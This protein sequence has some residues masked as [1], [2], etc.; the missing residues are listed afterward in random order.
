M[1]TL[2]KI[3]IKGNWATLVLP[4][5]KDNSIDFTLL[6]EQID[7]LISA[8]VD[9]IYS[10][11]STGEFYNISETEFDKCSELLAEKCHSATIDFQVGVS[12]MSPMLSLERL[13][14]TIALRPM[15]VQ[16]ILPDWFIPT[17]DESI[18]FLQKMEETAD[19]LGLVLYNPPH[20]KKQLNIG[21]IELLKK[22]VR[23][24]VGI[25]VAGGDT[26]WYEKMSRINSQLSVFIPGHYLATGIKHGAH[27]SYS[28]MAC[29]NPIAAQRWYQS[30]MVDLRSALELEKRIQQFINQYMAPFIVKDRYSNMAVDKF[31]IAVGG[32]LPIEP[33]LR[34]PY[35]AIAKEH[36]LQVRK[37]GGKMIPE[38]F[39]VK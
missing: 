5:N 39:D 13:K 28:N 36:I 37:E 7:I 11:G 18:S 38:F 12:H 23:S 2:Q 9:G 32:W 34:W 16:V 17:M 14:R 30:A 25:K 33:R 21:E 20:A 29:L 10:N 19:G 22:S 6:A 8:N 35:K 31:M 15:A 26:A 1:E 3:I 27:G 24:L 4:I